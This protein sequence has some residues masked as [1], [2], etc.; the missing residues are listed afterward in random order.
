MEP[1]SNYNI[2]NSSEPKIETWSDWDAE[3]KAYRERETKVEL[4]RRSSAESTFSNLSDSAEPLVF[5]ATIAP[6]ASSS[7]STAKTSEVAQH[8]LEVV[9][10]APREIEEKE[11]KAEHS[12]D[13]LSGPSMT[14]IKEFLPGIIIAIKKSREALDAYDRTDSHAKEARKFEALLIGGLFTEALKKLGAIEMP[15]DMSVIL[16]RGHIDVEDQLRTLEFVLETCE[17]EESADIRKLR[18]LSQGLVEG[19]PIIKQQRSLVRETWE[20]WSDHQAA[21]LVHLHRGDKK[22][23]QRYNEVRAYVLDLL[24]HCSD[25]K[26]PE[27]CEAIKTFTQNERS[28]LHTFNAHCLS[29]A[30]DLAASAPFSKQTALTESLSKR[31]EGLKQPFIA[32][33]IA[34][35]ESEVAQRERELPKQVEEA[36]KSWPVYC[37]VIDDVLILKQ[38]EGFSELEEWG[39]LLSSPLPGPEGNLEDIAAFKAALKA[40]QQKNKGNG[41]V[42]SFVTHTIGELITKLEACVKTVMEVPKEIAQQKEAIQKLKSFAKEERLDKLGQAYFPGTSAPIAE[43]AIAVSFLDFVIQREPSVHQLSILSKGVKARDAICEGWAKWEVFAKTGDYEELKK[44]TKAAQPT[45]SP[46]QNREQTVGDKENKRLAQL[47]LRN[48]KATKCKMAAALVVDLLKEINNRLDVI[49]VEKLNKDLNNSDPGKRTKAEVNLN[50]CKSNK[51][52][53]N[54]EREILTAY[55]K[56]LEVAGR[57][58]SL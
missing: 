39:G 21:A 50:F 53:V 46:K 56:Q 37:K 11:R 49:D 34:E 54:K 14:K 52:S 25:E 44:L 47:N 24:S 38:Q 2:N 20:S 31:L 15:K 12:T 33:L 22:A 1:N 32:Q 10:H 55:K 27:L 13:I 19:Y 18:A 29:M 42:E 45:G 8:S 57:M 51:D 28:K 30:I 26:R 16:S 3:I 43:K 17:R 48:F 6:P 7:S 36:L 35:K 40:F 23:Q 4:A 41:L 58:L 5:V 9:P